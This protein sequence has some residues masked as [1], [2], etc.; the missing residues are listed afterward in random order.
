M[1]PSRSDAAVVDARRRF[2]DAAHQ[3]DSVLDEEQR[4]AADRLAVL[5]AQVL[6]SRP[7]A[8]QS[9]PGLRRRRSPTGI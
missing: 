7:T 5:G 6:T 8:A 2:D 3:L 9:W 1:R 4:P